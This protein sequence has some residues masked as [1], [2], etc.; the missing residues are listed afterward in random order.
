MEEFVD[1]LSSPITFLDAF[2][3]LGVWKILYY[4]E[5]F[6]RAVCRAMRKES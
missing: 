5:Y 4:A 2:I 6:V 1:A 3:V